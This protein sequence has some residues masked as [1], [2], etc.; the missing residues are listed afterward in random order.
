MGPSP[1]VEV[2]RRLLETH[3]RKHGQL[4]EWIAFDPLTQM[5]LA[6]LDGRTREE[7]AKRAF[8]A[9]RI[10][11]DCWGDLL[12]CPVEEFAQLI[13]PV[14]YSDRKAN[15]IHQALK[16]ILRVRG[17]LSL[18]FLA[19]WAVDDARAWLERLPGV[20]PKVSAAVVNFSTLHMPALV[21]NSHY[22]RVAKRLGLVATHS[23]D[24]AV[25]GK[26]NQLVPQTMTVNDLQQ[27]YFLVKRH[28]QI[29]C[30]TTSPKCPI[31]PLRDIC[32]TGGGVGYAH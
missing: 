26:L 7:N 6:I 12:A 17:V 22:Q 30:Q 25:C 13:Q 4:G 14:T 23:N 27:H 20:G 28:G 9:L 1:L 5:I 15:Q 32:R 2:H 21:V 29:V 18:D 10:R 31:C 24:V 8:H 16:N 11:F 3:V 19:G